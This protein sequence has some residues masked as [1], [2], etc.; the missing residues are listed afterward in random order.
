MHVGMGKTGTTSLQTWLHRN[1]QRLAERGVLY[2]ASPGPRRHVRLGLCTQALDQGP[3]TGVDWQEQPVATPGQL[4]PL[5]EEEL[6]AELQSA[7]PR[8]LLS[9]EAL[10]GAGDEGLRYLH[11]LLGRIASSVRVVVYLRRQ[12]DHVSSRY[13]QVVKLAGEVRRLPEWLDAHDFSRKYDYHRRLRAWQSLVSPSSLAVRVFERERLVDGS[14]HS[15]FLDA[16]GL[17]LVPDDL[18]AAPDRNESLD[19]EAVELLRLYN[20]LR[21]EQ[22]GEI[23]GMPRHKRMVRRLQAASRGPMLT[24]PD[25]RLE[26]LMA[27]HVES[28]RAVARDF[29]AGAPETL[30]SPRRTSRPTTSVQGL[31]PARVDELLAVTRLPREVHPALHALAEREAEHP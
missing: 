24:L 27:R 1:R 16:T 28:N 17:G 2:P 14:L 13:Q 10:F 20:L 30:F 11:G 5:L 29:V 26:D 4:R 3:G 6:L 18:E 22:P 31:D 19:A 25:Q 15:D 12:D 23:A 21:Q 9:D 7:P 8:V